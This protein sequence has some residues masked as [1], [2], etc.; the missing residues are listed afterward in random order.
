[1]FT[2]HRFK[3]L[4]CDHL[5]GGGEAFSASTVSKNPDDRNQEKVYQQWE[6]KSGSLMSSYEDC[7]SP[8]IFSKAQKSL[9]AEVQQDISRDP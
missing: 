6:C 7:Q 3:G 1:M 9:H 8:E 4:G 2:V 5:P